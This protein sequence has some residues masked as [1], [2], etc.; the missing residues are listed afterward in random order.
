MLANNVNYHFII[1]NDDFLPC[2]P[3]FIY[4]F[5]R[6]YEIMLCLDR[7]F[8]K[9]ILQ[10]ILL[11]IVSLR[12]RVGSWVELFNSIGSNSIFTPFYFPDNGLN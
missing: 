11:F 2:N 3:C 10:N 12:S 4:L 6:Q 7:H 9:N 1:F 8:F 5:S